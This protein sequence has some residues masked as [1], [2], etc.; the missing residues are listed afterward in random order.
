MSVI[1]D[2][3]PVVGMMIVAVGLFYTGYRVGRTSNRTLG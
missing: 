1:V 3:V 2:L